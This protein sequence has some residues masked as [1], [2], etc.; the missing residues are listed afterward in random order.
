VS[1]TEGALLDEI[2]PTVSA[3]SDGVVQV[4]VAASDYINLPMTT[5]TCGP[6]EV[7]ATRRFVASLW[8]GTGSA[9]GTLGWRG[10]DGTTETTFV[11]AGTVYDADSLT[12]ASASYPIWAAAMWTGACTQA[13]LDA[14][15]VRMGFS[16]DATPDMGASAVYLE[17]A[18]REISTSSVVHRLTDNEDPEVDAA[19][20]TETLHP[21]NSAVRTFSV[22]NDHPT[23]TAEF[24]FYETGGA[25]HSL[26]PVVIAPTEPPEDITVAAEEFGEIEST[27]FT[28]Q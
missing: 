7:I 13:Q 16:T 12:T 22:S 20:V 10:W 28:W 8:G 15:A 4:S 17:V 11:A 5:Y 21:Y 25:E 3:S 9:T 26:S 6:G 23:K 24:R 1:G 18:V 14:A 19:V 27:R 2:P